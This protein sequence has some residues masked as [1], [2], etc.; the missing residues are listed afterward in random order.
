[1][2]FPKVTFKKEKELKIIFKNYFLLYHLYHLP[3][4]HFSIIIPKL[5]SHCLSGVDLRKKINWPQGPVKFLNN[6]PLQNSTG[7]RNIG[8]KRGI[9][10]SPKKQET[11]DRAI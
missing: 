10:P 4:I 2:K 1:V 5:R 9:C 6:W 3:Y 7:L 8:I 11:K